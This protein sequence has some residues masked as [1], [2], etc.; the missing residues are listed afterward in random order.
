MSLTCQLTSEDIKQ[1]YLPTS[2]H[3]QRPGEI[4]RR[5]VSWT[6]TK[7]LAQKRSKAGRWSWAT[8]RELDF[9]CFSCFPTAE[10]RTVSLSLFC[11]AVGTAIAW[12]GRR[13]AMPDG[14]CRNILLFW[15]RSTAA[16]VF[17]VGSC[18]EVSL[19]CPPFSHSS[20]SL[21]ALF[22]SVDVKQRSQSVCHQ[23]QQARPLLGGRGS[24]AGTASD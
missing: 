6:L 16:L 12:C 17:R 13:C 9:F 22:A 8:E 1:H 20:P 4:K 19:F 3:H 11:T 24:S 10:L 21:I 2:C 23:R 7:K 5:E 15:R 14:H 18:F